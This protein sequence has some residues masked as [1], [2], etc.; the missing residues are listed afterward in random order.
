MEKLLQAQ[1]SA[2]GKPQNFQCQQFS[3]LFTS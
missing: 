1:K 3:I 2:K